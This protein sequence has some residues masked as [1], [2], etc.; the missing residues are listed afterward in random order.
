MIS[1]NHSDTKDRPFQSGPAHSHY[2]SR[3]ITCQWL[4]VPRCA[5]GKFKTAYHDPDTATDLLDEPEGFIL[6]LAIPLVGQRYVS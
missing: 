5:E 1:I 2:D 4:L 3:K 6:P